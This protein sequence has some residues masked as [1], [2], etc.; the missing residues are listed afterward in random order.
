MSRAD[1]ESGCSSLAIYHPP[2]E[3]QPLYQRI[4]ILILPIPR[5]KC[6]RQRPCQNCIAR[7]SPSSCWYAKQGANGARTAARSTDSDDVRSRI[8][9]LESLVISLMP[10]H[11]DTNV[12]SGSADTL[13]RSEEA[14]LDVVH[15]QFNSKDFSKLGPLQRAAGPFAERLPYIG[16]S[17]WDAML[18]DVSIS[19]WYSLT[20][21]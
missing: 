10:E 12:S 2:A 15:S 7:E 5:L 6:D 19:T 20:R 1:L 16:E 14:E 9:R 17:K 13:E 18:R 8:N 21:Y 4:L 11:S 3:H